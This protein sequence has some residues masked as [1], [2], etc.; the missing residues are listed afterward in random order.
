MRIKWWNLVCG[1]DAEFIIIIIQLAES[2]AFHLNWEKIEECINQFS[3][4]HPYTFSQ[5]FSPL[6]ASP[7]VREFK[8]TRWWEIHVWSILWNWSL[9]GF[10][11][12]D[13]WVFNV[14]QKR[15]QVSS[16]NYHINFYTHPETITERSDQGIQHGS[17]R[18]W[19]YWS[20]WSRPQK[21]WDFAFENCCW[22]QW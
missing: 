6:F 1:N 11:E 13:Q 21:S 5:P 18:R 7:T 8:N 2:F 10:Q 20:S 19:K 4:S 14:F 17:T 16:L 9:V 12:E 22:I 3:W 15:R